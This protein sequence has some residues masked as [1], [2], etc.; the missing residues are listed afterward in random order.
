MR[1]VFLVPYVNCN[2]GDDIFIDIISRRYPQVRWQLMSSCADSCYPQENVWVTR[3]SIPV[4]ILSKIIRIFSRERYSVMDLFMRLNEFTVMLGGSM[5]MEPASMRSYSFTLGGGKPYYILGVNFGPYRTEAYYDGSYRLFAE[6]EDVCFRD[7]Y[8]YNL[9][10]KLVTTRQA[11]DII[12]GLDVTRYRRPATDNV[13]ISVIDCND[14]RPGLKYR[15]AYDARI[16]EFIRFFNQRGLSVTLMSFCRG[17]GDE[18]AI[19]R[20]MQLTSPE[21]MVDTYFYRGDLAEALSVIGRSKIVVGSRFH[22]NILGMIM[23]KTVIPIAYSD[24][25]LN[26]LRDI[27]FSGR[28]FD[29]RDME[30]FAV[31]SISDDDLR[32]RADV[33]Y[34]IAHAGEHFAKLDMLLNPQ[35]VSFSAD[36]DGDERD[37]RINVHSGGGKA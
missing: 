4:R 37:M 31:S 19:E 10:S 3:W 12:F 2:L 15:D 33:S 17:E 20:I 9:F 11:P 28:Y 32:Y 21:D 13:V 29:I 24:K 6:A 22:A 1:N 36:N 18:T 35:C 30:H 5:F 16:V 26:V 14:S 7:S 25:T 27:N 34:Q 23:D 8:S